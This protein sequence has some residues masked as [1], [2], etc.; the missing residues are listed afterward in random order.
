ML[1]R[2]L[3]ADASRSDGVTAI[4]SRAAAAARARAPTLVAMASHQTALRSKCVSVLALFGE[5]DWNGVPA[6]PVEI[7]LL[8]TRFYVNLYE[9][10]YW[11]RTVIVPL[12][13]LLDRKP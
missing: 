7:M 12:L 8:P 4:P 2:R 11:S 1:Q 5:Y 9:V 10:S 13:I 6:M 3:S